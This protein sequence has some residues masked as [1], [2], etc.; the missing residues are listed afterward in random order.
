M[1]LGKGRTDGT[2]TTVGVS[3][4]DV[5]TNLEFTPPTCEL[6][7]RVVTTMTC[8][9]LI[10]GTS[11]GNRPNDTKPPVPPTMT[12]CPIAGKTPS[13]TAPRSIRQPIVLARKRVPIA[14]PPR[15][16]DRCNSYCPV[17]DRI[18]HP[19]RAGHHHAGVTICPDR[20]CRGFSAL[21]AELPRRGMRC[22]L[23]PHFTAPS[24]MPLRKYRCS[25]MNTAITG[26]VISTAPAA[27]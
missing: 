13:E 20:T 23:A 4:M 27:M 8:P 17:A 10:N 6:K 15:P 18:I 19:S 22:G 5:T 12:P 1:G 11:E 25:K 26:S 9:V 2:P 7:V 14:T 16:W 24:M 3:A 21:C